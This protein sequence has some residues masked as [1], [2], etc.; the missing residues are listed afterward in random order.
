MNR[1]DLIIFK[2][3][4]ILVS[5]DVYGKDYFYEGR[6]ISLNEDSMMFR[7]RKDKLILIRFDKITKIEEG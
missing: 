7:D 4:R 6:V 3:K 2:D 1:E 5:V